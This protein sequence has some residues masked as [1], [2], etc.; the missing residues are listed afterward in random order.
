MLGFLT[1]E[2]IEAVLE[3]PNAETWSGKRDRALFATMYN[4]GARV[5]EIVDAKVSD[6][7][8]TTGGT[9]KLHGK[10]RKER[11]LPLW[12]PTVATLRKWIAANHLTPDRPLFT[13]ARG[14]AITRSGVEKRLEDAVRKA[15]ET[16]PSIKNKPVSPHTIRHTTAI[17]L[18][19]SGADTTVVAM[20]LGH[21]SIETTH[22]Y[23]T[24]T[25]ELKEKALQA[26]Q[27]PSGGNFRF[28]PSGKLLDFLKS[29]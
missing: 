11:V 2:E 15:G 19:Q 12:K 29:L 7:I 18:L 25:L 16:C 8:L 1:R 6:L 9:L 27:P 24:A 28:R 17:H 4:T 26:V 23:V 21:E 22:A 14:L 10:G 3:A 13:N 20:W 5:S